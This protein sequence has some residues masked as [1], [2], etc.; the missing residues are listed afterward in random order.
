MGQEQSFPAAAQLV[1]KTS[2]DT[3]PSAP[4][5][6]I[7]RHGGMA[8]LLALGAASLC[9]KCKNRCRP[10]A[11]RKRSMKFL[12]LNFSLACKSRSNGLAS[13]T[14]RWLR[15]SNTKS[16]SQTPF[17]TWRDARRRD[18]ASSD[19][20]FLAMLDCRA[21][22]T[23][24]TIQVTVACETRVDHTSS[25]VTFEKPIHCQRL[26]VTTADERMEIGRV[27]CI[28]MR[29]THCSISIVP[30]ILSAAQK[31]SYSCSLATP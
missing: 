2:V 31:R 5:K 8:A 3:T 23:Q 28:S 13:S 21:C 22:K 16:P 4:C 20:S 1:Q 7:L 19:S 25:G 27:T 30:A 6:A 26:K 11:S 10:S 17:K 29:S 18:D 15:R 9:R 12:P 24:N 14:I